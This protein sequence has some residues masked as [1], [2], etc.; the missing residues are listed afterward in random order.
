[1]SVEEQ[2]YDPAAYGGRHV[3]GNSAPPIACCQRSNACESSLGKEAVCRHCRCP[4]ERSP[5]CCE[6]F[7]GVSGMQSHHYHGARRQKSP[8]HYHHQHHYRQQ[9]T[10]GGVEQ[11][12]Q[13]SRSS[14]RR[15]FCCVPEQEELQ[16][17]ERLEKEQRYRSM[18]A[19]RQQLQAALY[20]DLFCGGTPRHEPSS[21]YSYRPN[22]AQLLRYSQGSLYQRAVAMEQERRRRELRK[23]IEARKRELSARGPMHQPIA[24]FTSVDGVKRPFGPVQRTR[25]RAFAKSPVRVCPTTGLKQHQHPGRNVQAAATKPTAVVRPR[26]ECRNRGSSYLRGRKH[27]KE[28]DTHVQDTTPLT[29]DTSGEPVSGPPAAHSLSRCRCKEVQKASSPAPPLRGGEYECR[30]KPC[31]C[32]SC[33]E[34]A[35]SAGAVPTVSHTVDAMPEAPRQQEDK[36]KPT[37]PLRAATAVPRRPSS[38]PACLRRTAID[39]GRKIY[40]TDDAHLSRRAKVIE[41]LEQDGYVRLL[42]PTTR[43][44]SAPLPEKARRWAT[45][46]STS[47]HRVCA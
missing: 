34:K 10:E 9:Q 7:Q 45:T 32:C 42:T 43:S 12:Q 22:T 15:C 28:R 14:S 17:Y 31:R 33:A 6:A 13:G 36:E 16:E 46:R 8:P 21:D 23:E 30:C 27:H 20:D 18:R 35:H 24:F 41:L 11:L 39:Y 29:A 25:G 19:E 47:A 44:P 5:C 4:A 2:Q 1:M 38:L 3:V 26:C 40:I 37:A